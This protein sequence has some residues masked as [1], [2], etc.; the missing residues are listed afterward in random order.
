MADLRGVV[1]ALVLT[2]GCSCANDPA[3]Q[4]KS[5]TVDVPAL[6]ARLIEGE[7]RLFSWVYP[8]LPAEGYPIDFETGGRVQTE[9][10]A[11]V[12]T[13]WLTEDLTLQLASRTE[14]PRVSLYY[15]SAA[16]VFASQPETEPMAGFVIGP[17]GFG[18]ADYLPSRAAHTN[19]AR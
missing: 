18:F 15:D 11:M 13:W 8:V 5:V 7:W 17:I 16:G 2:T 14:V 9:N 4:E 6:R 10:L 19:R 12:E 1:V 3:R